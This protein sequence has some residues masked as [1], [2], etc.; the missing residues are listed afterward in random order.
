MN[1]TK[2]L[3]ISG[4]NSFGISI[5]LPLT[6]VYYLLTITQWQTAVNYLQMSSSEWK[7]LQLAFNFSINDKISN[8]NNY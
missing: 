4:H 1:T 7:Q 2:L 6:I 5:L 8:T 3:L